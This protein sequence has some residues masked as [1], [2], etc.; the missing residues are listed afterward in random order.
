MWCSSSISARDSSS[1]EDQPPLDVASD[2]PL[3]GRKLIR[4]A[5]EHLRRIHPL[6]IRSHNF[7]VV[8][9]RLE[10]DAKRTSLVHLTQRDCDRIADKLRNRPR[11]RLGFRTPAES[12]LLNTAA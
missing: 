2:A 11:K 6:L 12:Y 10:F 3:A 1:L 7:E 9:A 4:R 5:A 8:P